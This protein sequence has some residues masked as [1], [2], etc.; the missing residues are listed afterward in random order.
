MSKH[1]ASE[2]RQRKARFVP[3]DRDPLL[4]PRYLGE[5][6]AQIKEFSD[7]PLFGQRIIPRLPLVAL[8]K[9]SGRGD[10]E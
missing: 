5:K 1:A 8:P 4:P 7:L 9:G 6:T 3:I 2:R 10:F